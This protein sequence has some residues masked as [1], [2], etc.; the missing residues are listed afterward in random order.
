MDI[1]AQ[2]RYNKSGYIDFV[3][4]GNTLESPFVG[5]MNSPQLQMMD[6]NLELNEHLNDYHEIQNSINLMY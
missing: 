6:L 1:N 2:I 3:Q 5:G 4:N